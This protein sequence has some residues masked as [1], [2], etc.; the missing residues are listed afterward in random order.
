MGE[1]E[2]SDFEK[3]QLL[4]RH[5]ADQSTDI[6]EALLQFLKTLPPV[7]PLMLGDRERRTLSQAADEMSK[8]VIEEVGDLRLVLES[9]PLEDLCAS[10]GFAFL[11]AGIRAGHLMSE[12]QYRRIF[13]R[14]DENAAAT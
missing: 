12:D 1:D 10:T 6:D 8:M 4:V 3:V 2:L 14:E 5:D 13:Q 9:M 11:V 7:D